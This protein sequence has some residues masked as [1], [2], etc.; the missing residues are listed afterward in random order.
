MM[1][2]RKAELIALS[3]AENVL[4]DP[5]V[6]ED[7]SKDRSFAQAMKPGF[8]VKPVNV[9]QVQKIVRWAKGTGTPLVPVSSGPPHF[10]GDTVAGIPGAV[11]VDLSQMNKIIKIDRRNRL[12]VIEPGV[13][14]GQL[15][16][17]LA[18]AGLRLSTS[19][20]PRANKSVITSLLEREPRLNAR[21]QWSSLDPLRSMEVVWG[22][23]NRLWTGG[24]GND[25]LDLEQQMSQQKWPLDP[26]GPAQTDFYR[27]LSAAQGSMGIATWATVRCEVLPRVHRL[28]FVPA[29][30][31]NDLF[32][33][34]YKILRFRYADEIFL[35]NNASLA[36]M[37]GGSNT[38]IQSLKDQ[39]PPWIA[40]VG[41]AGRDELPEERVDFQQKDIADIARSFGLE[42]KSALPGAEGAQVL[43]LIM[44]PSREPYWKL[45]YKGG[46]QDIFFITTLE[47]THE[48]VSSILQ[49]A[50]SSGYPAADIGV[51]IQPRHQGVNCHCEFNLPYSPPD[52]HESA[53]VQYLFARASKALFD[54][55]AFFTRPYGI[56]A[57]F[58]FEKDPS[59]TAL[60]KKIKGIF[61]PHGI[62]NPGKL[63]FT[64]KATEE[65]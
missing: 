35:V 63:C 22:D 18:K 19:L 11:V 58:A 65:K 50:V 57:D 2:D 13:T 44:Q 34:T 27:F 39:L 49:T 4:D 64:L 46:C 7:Y 17:E 42:L 51:Y 23:G 20:L 37:I 32:D 10:R 61:D 21:Y 6:L 28:F 12:A 38:Q 30:H 25:V 1:A 60:L 15:Q 54:Q 55:G 59:S 14:C 9:D 41:I 3:G 56:W 26:T 33:F 43:D 53:L 45:D 40:I 8:V 47:M 62:M 52:P 31:L 24:P 5:R 16:P 48:F 29:G 36:Y